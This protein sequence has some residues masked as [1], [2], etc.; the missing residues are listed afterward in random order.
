MLNYAKMHDDDLI[1]LAV[2][3]HLIPETE[4]GEIDPI[5]NKEFLIFLLV[6]HYSRRPPK[7]C[8]QFLCVILI[9]LIICSIEF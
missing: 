1:Q 5:F 6:S 8:T 2:G 7:E 9:A 3:L 4:E